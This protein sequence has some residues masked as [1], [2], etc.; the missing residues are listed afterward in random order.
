MVTQEEWDKLTN[1]YIRSFQFSK[2]LERGIHAFNQAVEW[3]TNEELDKISKLLGCIADQW[4]VNLSEAQKEASMNS[5]KQYI[6]ELD[7]SEQKEKIKEIFDSLS[8]I[9]PDATEEYRRPRTI[10]RI[11]DHLQ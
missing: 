9:P 6:V 11:E 1:S 5:L 8:E 4:S 2:S 10:K 3:L 7:K